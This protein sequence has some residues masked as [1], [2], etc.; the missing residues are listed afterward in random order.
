ML[1]LPVIVIPSLLYNLLLCGLTAAAAWHA[2]NMIEKVLK[3]RVRA[4][5]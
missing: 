1:D 3:G 4:D 2:G 5:K